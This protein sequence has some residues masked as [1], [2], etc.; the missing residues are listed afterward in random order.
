[1]YI[2]LVNSQL[3][4]W[5]KNSDYETIVGVLRHMENS[6]PSSLSGCFVKLWK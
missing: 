2:I 5:L 3:F 1:M 4:H 6:V